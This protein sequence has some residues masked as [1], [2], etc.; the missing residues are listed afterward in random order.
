MAFIS[1]TRLHLR[2]PWLL[3]V[4]LVYTQAS[5]WQARRSKGLRDG[6]FGNDSGMGF[7]TVTAWDSGES[8]QAFRATS[9]HKRAMPKL[10]RWCDEAAVTHWEQDDETA[11]DGATAHARLRADGRRSKLNAPSARHQRGATVGDEVAKPGFRLR[12]R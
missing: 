4:F 2:S 8:M 5:A 3:P 1:V 9:F 6:W 10:I 12:P 7:W 11:P